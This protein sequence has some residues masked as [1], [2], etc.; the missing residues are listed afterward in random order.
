M[1]LCIY[2]YKE[3]NKLII[4]LASFW[5]KITRKNISFW[6]P[7]NIGQI[8]KRLNLQNRSRSDQSLL[9]FTVVNS[10]LYMRRL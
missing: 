6:N 9:T 5:M 2:I 1:Y 8:N 4:S 7:S 10:Q 3:I